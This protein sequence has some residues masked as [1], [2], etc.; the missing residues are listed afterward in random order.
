[1]NVLMIV[2]DDQRSDMIA[3]QGNR[4]VS[5]PNMDRLVNGGFS[6]TLAR[7]MG[8][9]VGAVCIAARAMIH[10]GRSLFVRR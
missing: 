2:A 5:T 4:V 6:F 10:T 9:Q 7:C 8:S 1:M 3:A